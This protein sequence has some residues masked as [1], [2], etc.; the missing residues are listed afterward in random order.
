MSKYAKEENCSEIK[1][2]GNKLSLAVATGEVITNKRVR[3]CSKVDVEFCPKCGKKLGEKVN[4]GRRFVCSDCGSDKVYSIE[5]RTDAGACA[6]TLNAVNE[7]VEDIAN[8][9][10]SKYL[11][12]YYCHKCQGF[13]SVVEKK[14]DSC[15]S[16]KMRDEP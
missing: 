5:F 6:R 8:D 11:G 2:V 4:V 3:I 12:G 7:G 15:R 9:D 14:D 1:I 13:C 10:L 16:R